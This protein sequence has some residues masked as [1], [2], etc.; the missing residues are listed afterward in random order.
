VRLV[1]FGMACVKS[2]H[3]S[4]ILS[5]LTLQADLLNTL[6]SLTFRDKRKGKKRR[7]L[8]RYF[9][10]RACSSFSLSSSQRSLF[11]VILKLN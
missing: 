4:A 6:G 8:A 1:V 10:D 7:R 2:L 3:I 11:V 5:G 9:K